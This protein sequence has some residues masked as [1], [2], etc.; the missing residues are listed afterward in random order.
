MKTTDFVPGE[1]L[2]VVVIRNTVSAHR[3][4]Q[5]DG[6]LKEGDEITI[7]HVALPGDFQ[8]VTCTGNSNTI[9]AKDV[10]RAGPRVK[11]PSNVDVWEASRGYI[12]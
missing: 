7:S 8:Y 11:Q 4:K 5:P 10:R 1:V 3:Q 2:K 6:Y 9:P 12:R